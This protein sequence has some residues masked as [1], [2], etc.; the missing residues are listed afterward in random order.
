MSQSNFE[1]ILLHLGYPIQDRGSY[2]QS[3]A[4]YRNGDNPHAL[5]IY[6]DTGVW[7]DYVIDSGFLPF[8]SLVCKTIG[9]DKA[10]DLLSGI[11]IETPTKTESNASLSSVKFFSEKDIGH[12]LPHFDFYFKKGISTDCLQFLKSGLCTSGSMYQRFVFPI[13]D[14]HHR[15]IGLAGRDLSTSDSRPKWKHMG[16]KTSWCYPFYCRDKSNNLPIKDSI[17]SS[18]E[19]I[20]VESIGDMLSLYCNGYKNVIVTFGLD[21]SP[22]LISLL[23]GLNLNRVIIAFNNDSSKEFNPGL[24]GSVKSFLKLSYYFNI[25]KIIIC[26]PTQNDFGDMNKDDLND[27]LIKL[28]HVKN[29]HSN[30]IDKVIKH[31]Q[32]FFSKGKI[33]KNLYNNIKY[34]T[35]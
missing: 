33:S 31:S 12:L 34:L 9:D 23:L 14:Q 22:S 10:K 30:L 3:P 32:S 17:L 27:W 24:I 35:K 21:I 13:F 26:L 15:I 18:R 4:L 11:K 25:D 1:D 6:K 19:V 28:K 7:K 29:N 16:K 8:K 2:W 5:Q 20:L